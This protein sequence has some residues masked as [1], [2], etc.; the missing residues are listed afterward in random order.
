MNVLVTGGGTIAYIDE[1]RFIANSSSGSF[2]ATITETLLGMGA[3]V[4]HLHTPGAQVPLY[5][6]MAVSPDD[7]EEG[8]L[9]GET[10][11]E[12][13]LTCNESWTVH[14]KR[15][16]LVE[17]D[18][19]TV[20]EYAMVLEMLIRSQRFDIIFL[21]MAVSDF[22]PIKSPGKIESGT[23][24]LTLTLK[25]T[26]KIIARV[27][28]W[29]PDSFLVGFKLM[30]SVDESELIE[31]A[32]KACII[33]RV[34]VTLANDL[35][36]YRAGKHTVHLVQADRPAETFAPDPDMPNQLTMR[37]LELADAKRGL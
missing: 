9:L 12:K 34:D 28:D 32:R 7:L 26:P 20:S 21:A 5:R 2:S 30:V 27:R 36:L 29:S 23:E 31:T 6:M 19:G 14:R 18:E 24:D 4:W 35:T 8:F 1:V 17:L 25:P 22:E 3:N 33:N 13:W 11:L 10:F 15:L 37:I 16:H